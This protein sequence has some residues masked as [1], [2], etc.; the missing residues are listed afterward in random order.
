MV[1]TKL[2]LAVGIFDARVL[3]AADSAGWAGVAELPPSVKSAFE[4]GRTI[5]TD[6]MEVSVQSHGTCTVYEMEAVRGRGIQMRQGEIEAVRN[7]V[8]DTHD[9]VRCTNLDLLHLLRKTNFT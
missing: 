5:T 7:A 9:L 3:N 1:S 4:L 6:G 8:L 2:S